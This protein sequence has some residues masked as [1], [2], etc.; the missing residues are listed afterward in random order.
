MCS[1]CEEMERRARGTI[2]Q[3]HTSPGPNAAFKSK[4]E[5]DPTLEQY[6]RAGIKKQVSPGKRA[7]PDWSPWPGS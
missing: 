6:H 5:L 2:F 3:G 1:V 4:S 7:E